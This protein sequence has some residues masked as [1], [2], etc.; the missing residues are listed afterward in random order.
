MVG[1]GVPASAKGAETQP[2]IPPAARRGRATQISGPLQLQESYVLVHQLFRARYVQPVAAGTPVGTTSGSLAVNANSALETPAALV[3]IP[4]VQS[5]M[6][7]VQSR[8]KG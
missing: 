8:P 6:P 3:Q 2:E 1:A 4:M 5:L 7:A